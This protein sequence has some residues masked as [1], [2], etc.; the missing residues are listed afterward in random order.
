MLRAERLE[1]PKI[2]PGTI[3]FP[4]CYTPTTTL[5]F[6]VILT[7]YMEMGSGLRHSARRSWAAAGVVL[8]LFCLPVA[9]ERGQLHNLL[10]P[11][12]KF[13]EDPRILQLGPPINLRV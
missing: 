4:P 5:H 11:P 2:R 13:R 9:A 6:R 12:E 1:I 3:D 8:F 10:T 7:S